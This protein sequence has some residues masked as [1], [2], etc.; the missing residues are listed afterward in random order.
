MTWREA[1]LRQ[2]ESDYRIFR[3]LN[4]SQASVP[5]CHQLHYLQMATEKLAKA[6]TCPDA[7]YPPKATHVAFARFLR[8]MKGRPELRRELGYQGNYNAF[9]S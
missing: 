5:V 6:L 4:H 1:F 8:I 2:A 3:D 9:A 7:G